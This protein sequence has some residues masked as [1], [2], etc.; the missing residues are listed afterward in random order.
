MIKEIWKP[1]PGYEGLYEV[2][3]KGNVRSLNYMHTGK[4]KTIKLIKHKNGYLMVCL[5]KDGKIKQASVHRLVASA[6]IPNPD[7]L[8]QVNHKDENK[9]NNS[10]DNLEWCDGAYNMKYGT[11]QERIT[12][13]NTNNPKKSKPIL[14]FDLEGNLIMKWE[15]LNEVMRQTGVGAGNI[16]NCARGKVKTAGGYVWKYA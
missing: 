7:N 2:S 1:I 11:R 14:Q 9:L 3:N 13:S 5:C 6:F 10:V 8:P 15:S 4:W 16:S 12:K